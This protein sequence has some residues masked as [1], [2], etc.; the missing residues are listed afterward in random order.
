MKK[1]LNLIIGLALYG[2]VALAQ[3]VSETTTTTAPLQ[4]AG[5]VTTIDPAT[6]SFVVTA[7]NVAPA[8]YTYTTHTAIVDASGNPV[9]IDVVKAG[10]PVTVYYTRTGDQMVVS[11]MVVQSPAAVQVQ[12]TT[13]TTTTTGQ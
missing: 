8:T 10:V 3:S 2:G 11:R 13:T 6:G 9:G 4:E 7:P 1:P 5:S 12:K